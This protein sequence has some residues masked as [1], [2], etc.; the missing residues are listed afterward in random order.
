MS[1]LYPSLD[2]LVV[3]VV[4]ETR[5]DSRLKR[6]LIAQ[7][8]SILTKYA[9]MLSFIMI[10]TERRVQTLESTDNM[11]NLIFRSLQTR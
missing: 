10:D 3:S 1:T 7:S 4:P 9:T 6:E 2:A 5:Y 8:E 11:K